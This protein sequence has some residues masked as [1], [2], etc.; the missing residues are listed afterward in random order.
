MAGLII[1][2]L[3]GDVLVLRWSFLVLLIPWFWLT[4]QEPAYVLYA[5]FFNLVYWGTM[6]PELKQFVKI[7]KQG[8]LSTQSEVA[9]DMA[10]GKKLGAFLDQYGAPALVR[11]GLM[12][13]GKD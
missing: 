11:K 13:K 5:V 12:R 10:M 7:L 3:V 6:S 1:G 2:W 9:G 8:G 4:K